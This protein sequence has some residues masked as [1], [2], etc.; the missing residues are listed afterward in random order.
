MEIPEELRDQLSFYPVRHM[1]EVIARAFGDASGAG[2]GAGKK[3]RKSRSKAGKSEP[4]TE[5]R[6]ND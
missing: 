5:E 2:A 1:D 6:Q 3:P 4:D